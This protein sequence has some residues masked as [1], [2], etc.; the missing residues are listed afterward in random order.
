MF[1]FFNR[2]DIKVCPKI[3]SN[4]FLLWEPCSQSHAEIIPGFAKYLL[5]LGYSVSVL[6][7]PERIDEGLFSLVEENERIY[8]NRM[9]RKDIQRFLLKYGLAGAKGLLISTITNK[10][11]IK[12]I[13]L[14]PEQKILYVSHDIKDDAAFIDEKTITLRSVSDNGNEFKTVVVN[15]HYFGTITASAK[16]N[17]VN[18]ISIGAL[19]KK[20]RNAALLIEAAKK[21]YNAGVSDFRITVVGKEMLRNI[22]K[23][24]LP[25]FR[26]LGRLDFQ[27]MY[28]EI[29]N[30]DFFL[31]LLDPLN[32]KHD[33]YITTG[34]SGSFQLIYGFLKPPIIASRFA[35]IN[36]FDNSNS[37][38][39]E[40]NSELADAMEK[41][42][43]MTTEDYSAMRN[44]LKRYVEDLYCKSLENLRRLIEVDNCKTIADNKI[45]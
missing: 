38:I 5:D 17:I 29:Q 39:Y 43:R 7:E 1:N 12:D 16:N 18:F 44:N 34:T 2:N 42:M 33:R 37:I 26:I 24:L 20:R 13:P 35:P 6:I 3:D 21:I 8:L 30:A 14:A 36:G 40:N 32:P 22:P 25:F 27:E 4:T 23:E 28:K 9:T 15:P 11:N 19:S 10:I 41:A 31:P 45:S